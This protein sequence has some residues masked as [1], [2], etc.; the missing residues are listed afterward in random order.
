MQGTKYYGVHLGEF[1]TPAKE[2]D[3][4]YMPPN[5]YYDQEDY[6]VSKVARPGTKWTW[7]G[8][9][10]NPVCGWAYGNPMNLVS[11]I[12]VYGSICKELDI[13]MRFP[14]D[15]KA[16]DILLEVVDVGLLTE[17]MVWAATHTQGQN[18]AF[19]ISNGDVFRWRN[20]WPDIAKF[21][22]L[23]T[24][25]PQKISLTEM[26]ADKG[27]LWAQMQKKH[28]LREIPYKD[29]VSWGFAEFV[30]TRDYDWFSDVNKLR[31]HGFHGQTLDSS[32]MF[33]RQLQQLRLLKII[34]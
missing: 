28:G 6:L 24:G 15:E 21:F 17:A 33:V 4:R 7:S 5:Y 16:Y 13:P 1:K 20:V 31:R 22:G 32:D 9:R 26:M 10:P 11:A 27:T 30:F 25:S 18:Q 12:G 34:P 3:P 2:D 23:T 8:V 29:L 19:N 14:G